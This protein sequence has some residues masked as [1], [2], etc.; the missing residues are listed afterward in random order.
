MLPLRSTQKES[1][2]G[3]SST[4]SNGEG[5]P[6]KQKV[7]QAIQATTL[8]I[9]SPS[10]NTTTFYYQSPYQQGYYFPYYPS[11]NHFSKVSRYIYEPNFGPPSIFTASLVHLKRKACRTALSTIEKEI[12]LGNKYL[13][14]TISYAMLFNNKSTQELYESF[15]DAYQNLQLY[16]S[17]ISDNYWRE[18]VNKLQVEDTTETLNLFWSMIIKDERVDQASKKIVTPLPSAG[19]KTAKLMKDTA[20]V[21]EKKRKDLPISSSNSTSSSERSQVDSSET[22]QVEEIEDQN[23]KVKEKLN[24]STH[25]YNVVNLI[26]ENNIKAAEKVLA[27]WDQKE[28]T[29]YQ[30]IQIQL[31]KALI[32]GLRYQEKDNMD[33]QQLKEA[34]KIIKKVLKELEKHPGSYVN[35]KFLKKQ[36]KLIK[37]Y[38]KVFIIAF[39]SSSS[40]S[41]NFNTIIDNFVKFP[42]EKNN[43]MRY[44]KAALKTALMKLKEHDYED[45]L[46]YVEKSITHSDKGYVEGRKISIL[47][48]RAYIVKAAILFHLSRAKNSEDYLTQA[49]S[50]CRLLESSADLV[51]EKKKEELTEIVEK[52]LKLAEEP[53]TTKVNIN[54]LLSGF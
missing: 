20:K 26:K 5:P 36:A 54:E 18:F 49:K 45:A 35:L 46:T 32:I 17:S 9:L 51:N 1:V 37:N 14:E 24:L 13:I 48:Y 10:E 16:S 40:V 27:D 42:K 22:M 39:H 34:K 43:E 41:I 4:P 3:N 38:L 30:K 7:V 11:D 8:P 15:R 44:S 29:D 31:I 28:N 33:L 50:E 53:I 19:N 6:K 21:N 25:L 23:S 2:A 52:L 47:L 12:N